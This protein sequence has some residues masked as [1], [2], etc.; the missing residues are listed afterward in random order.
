MKYI[1]LILALLLVSC[2][3]VKF[4][5]QPVFFS[6]KTTAIADYEVLGEVKG[7]G[8]KHDYE[9]LEQVLK[10]AK[11]LGGDAVIDLKIRNESYANYFNFYMEICPVVTGTAIRFTDG[12][13]VSS[14]RAPVQ[15][16]V[17]KPVPA[18]PVQQVVEKPAPSQQKQQNSVKSFA[19]KNYSKI[20]NDNQKGSGE[21]L[22]SLI[23]LM[24]NEGIPKDEALLLVKKA[25]RKSNGKAGIFGN[26]IEQSLSEYY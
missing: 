2:G 18:K 3:S 1:L 11:S 4:H 23:L 8:C 25:L 16:V 24:E 20:A 12:G 6:T 22:S 17:E 21:Y 7:D 19:E 10:E 14:V 5:K 13:S 9:L 15:R 26:E